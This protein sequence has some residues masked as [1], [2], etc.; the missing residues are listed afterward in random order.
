M[1]N[2][3]TTVSPKSKV[4]LSKQPIKQSF[5]P[6]VRKITP[7]FPICVYIPN[8]STAFTQKKKK[9]NNND[10]KCIKAFYIPCTMY[11][12]DMLLQNQKCIN[13]LHVLVFLGRK[14]SH[15]SR[16]KA[17]HHTILLTYV[18]RT[19]SKLCRGNCKTKKEILH[20]YS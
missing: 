6:K 16:P 19:P 13:H 18:H 1:K 12:F 4:F 9:S 2:Y 3:L 15:P 20:W 11:K 17:D 14:Q 8:Q 7:T 5:L 10:I